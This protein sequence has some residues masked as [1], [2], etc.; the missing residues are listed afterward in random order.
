MLAEIM[1]SGFRIELIKGE[2]ALTGD[3]TKVCLG[4]R[5]PQRTFSMAHGAVAINGVAEL[6]SNLE[7]D[8]TT[9]ARAL[10]GLDHPAVDNALLDGERRLIVCRPLEDSVVCR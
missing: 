6:G 2:I 8:T 5:M 7:R 4:R 1:L 9:M 3:D 10:V